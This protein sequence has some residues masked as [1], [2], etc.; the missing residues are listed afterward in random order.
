MVLMMWLGAGGNTAVAVCGVVP[1]VDIVPVFR[2][3]AGISGF[4]L[5]QFRLGSAG[6][7]YISCDVAWRRWEH[8]S[9][10]VRSLVPVAAIVLIAAT[11]P[12]FPASLDGSAGWVVSVVIIVLV[13][14]LGAGGN[15]VVAVCGV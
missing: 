7:L 1:V 2:Y 11:V 3:S 10:S 12:I 8:S 4:P 5:Q 9:G 6:C 14:L 13:I 15:T